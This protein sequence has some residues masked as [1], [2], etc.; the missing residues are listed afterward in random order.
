MGR[1]SLRVCRAEGRCPEP[2]RGG[3]NFVL[4]G[5]TGAFQ[6]PASRDFRRIAQ[7]RYR[8]DPEV[9]TARASR[10]P[11][12]DYPTGRMTLIVFRTCHALYSV[13]AVKFGCNRAY[14]WAG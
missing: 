11:N 14:S 9:S 5:A 10:Q 1:N 13:T 4:S 6:M 12:S 7:N 3:C 2:H 8:E